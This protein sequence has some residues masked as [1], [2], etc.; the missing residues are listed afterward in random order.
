MTHTESLRYWRAK[1]DGKLPLLQLPTDGARSASRRFSP[2]Q[3]PHALDP[4]LVRALTRVAGLMQQELWALFLGAF[5]VLLSRYSGQAELLVG[6]QIGPDG[7]AD[8]YGVHHA[9]LS[10]N[11]SLQALAPAIQADAVDGLECGL[12]LDEWEDA[13]KHQ[14]DPSYPPV[15]QAAFRWQPPSAAGA[16]RDV[17]LDVTEDG[18][19][20]LFTI[21]YDQTLFEPARIARMAKHLTVLLSA[22]VS[23]PAL[24]V[25]R[26]PLLTAEERA[27]IERWNDTRR[28]FPQESTLHALFEKQ[29]A[30][31]PDALAAEYEDTS[32]TY[33]ELDARANQLARCLRT[34]GVGPDTLVGLMLERSLEMAVGIL[35]VWKAG[36][37]YVP[38][39]PAYPPERLAFML[40]DSS[41]PVLL[42]Q[43]ALRDRL[44]ATAATVMA[45][46]ADWDAIASESAE[47]LA[48][49]AGPDN[50]AYVIYTSGSTGK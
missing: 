24:P 3:H 20:L 31:T 21:R 1:F 6:L 48:A 7:D 4:A 17:S 9:D 41:A 44:P 22:V 28:P 36:G 33:R 14:L 35:G 13:F 27:Q 40:A 5:E 12:R 10:D 26:L 15:F 2:G 34:H 18:G 39:D 38:M 49:T 19:T 25:G 47:P 50:L 37:A 8:R 16:A 43:A 42:T 23:D 45:L 32:L 29:A 46:D 11:P 30:R